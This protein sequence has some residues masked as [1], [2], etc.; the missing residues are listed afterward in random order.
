M[1]RCWGYVAHECGQA[2]LVVL[3]KS[4]TS[5]QGKGILLVVLT[6][7]LHMAQLSFPFSQQVI[8]ETLECY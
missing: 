3:N 6:S 4:L 5:G 1:L 8:E 7:V 2:L